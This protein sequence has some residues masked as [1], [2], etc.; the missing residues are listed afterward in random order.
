[1]A[2]LLCD[3]GNTAIKLGIAE[4]GSLKGAYALPS[5]PA[6]TADSLG[7]QLAAL[8]AHAGADAVE[9][10]AAVSVAPGLDRVLA[11]AARRYLGCGALFAQRDLP[12]PLANRCRRPELTGADRLVA[13]WAARLAF[14]EAAGLV[15]ADFGTAVTFDCV[16]GDVFL[17]G[18]IF[19]GPAIAL[20][21][22]A[23]RTAKLPLLE[24]DA[25]IGPLAPGRDTAEAIQLG[26]GHGYAAAAQGLCQGL[27][28]QLPEPVEIVATGGLAEAM[29][30]LAPV[31]DA[32]LPNLV[33]DGLLALAKAAGA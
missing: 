6:P 2:L 22:L 17:G 26:I 13:A 28:R 25:A 16:A 30:A 21:C 8:A 24:L 15:V 12:I 7:L 11:D 31:F 33:L 5:R 29:G 32:V 20:E 9:L 18:L 1:M 19:P 27:R 4:R 23:A 14:P 10:C 3:I